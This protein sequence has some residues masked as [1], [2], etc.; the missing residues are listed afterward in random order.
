MGPRVYGGTVQEGLDKGYMF[1]LVA[2]GDNHQD[3]PGVWGNGLMAVFAQELSRRSIW[4]AFK[5]RRVYG[6][7]GDRIQLYFSANGYIMGEAFASIEPLTMKVKVIGSHAVDRIEIIK[8]G[9]VLY[10]YCHQANGN[11]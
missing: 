8:N 3:F 1:G 9:K 5:K 10:T 11:L 2:S 4:E 7:T 6:V